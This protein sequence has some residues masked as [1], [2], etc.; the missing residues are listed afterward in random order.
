MFTDRI[1]MR[2]RTHILQTTHVPVSWK[3]LYFFWIL[4]FL[5]INEH[6]YYY[7]IYIYYL[8]LYKLYNIYIYILYFN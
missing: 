7:I 1:V 4:L 6:L 8:H 3:L 5:N 2:Q